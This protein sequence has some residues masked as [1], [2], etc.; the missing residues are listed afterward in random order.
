VRTRP[1]GKT[2]LEV[3]ELSLGT[4]GLSGDG[5]G[6]VNDDV[7]E[8]VIARAL[9]LGITVYDTA[10]VYGGGEMENALGRALP[11]APPRKSDKPNGGGVIVPT[12][13]APAVTETANHA[14]IVPAGG[15][16]P[17]VGLP[18][19]VTPVPPAVADRAGEAGP[20]AGDASQAG[21]DHKSSSAPSPAMLAAEAAHKAQA[22]AAGAARAARAAAMSQTKVEPATHALVVTKIGTDLEEGRKRFD[23]PYLQK[24][25]ER[26]CQRLGRCPDV[27]LMHNPTRAAFTTENVAFLAGLRNDKQIRA[28]GVS[29]G[30]V[31]VGRAAL[32]RGADVLELAYNVFAARDLHELAAEISSTGAGVLARSVLSHGLLAGQWS[33]DRE[34]YSGDHRAERWQPSELRRR[35]AQLDA[36]RPLVTGTVRTLRSL[37]LRFALANHLVSSVVLGPRSVPQLEQLVRDAGNG[38]PYLRDTAMTDMTNRL[39]AVGVAL[40]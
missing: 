4:W 3:S 6:A 16:L 32:D 1:L 28:W 7:A 15:T 8:K 35:I 5:Y 27:L 12:P 40:S 18:P 29:A 22:A 2:G 17:G 33:A 39:K 26:C 31:E 19:T 37:A 11:P 23:V 36:L 20:P 9:A 34:F 10:D 30:S 38:P 21:A 25:F 13:G 14:A 24:A